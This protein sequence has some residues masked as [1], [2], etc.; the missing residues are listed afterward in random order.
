MDQYVYV[1]ERLANASSS[2]VHHMGL[3]C[4]PDNCSGTMEAAVGYRSQKE[5]MLAR[6]AGWS[7]FRRLS[8]LTT[9]DTK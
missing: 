7:L 4:L 3:G 1:R 9:G 2:E 5:Y 8:P 6:P